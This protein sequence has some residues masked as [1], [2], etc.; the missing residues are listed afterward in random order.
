M[1][2]FKFTLQ[3]V[4]NVREMKQERE[5]LV[6]SELQTE[7]D[8]AAA[9]VHEIEELRAKAIES[10]AR[11]LENGTAIDPY[12]LELSSNH[13]SALDRMHREAQKILEKKKQACQRQTKTVEI[14]AR[15]VKI[16]NRLRENQ[17]ARHQADVARHEQNSLDEIVS[18]NYARQMAQSK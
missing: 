6:L 5:L 8:K 12:E 15:D 14:A 9:R 10:Y 11:R 1:K 16:T 4:H 7:T 2:K 3:T 17:Q 18:A 13:I